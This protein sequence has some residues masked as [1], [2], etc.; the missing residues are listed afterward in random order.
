MD[1]PMPFRAEAEIKD[2]ADDSS[3]VIAR[4]QAGDDAAFG[5]LFERHYRFVY[6]FIYAMRGEQSA[7]EELTQETF[8]AAYKN[9]RGLR[10]EA[11]LQTWLCAIAK[12]IIYKS[13][14]LS[15]KE[16]VQSADEIESFEMPDEK[17]L[18]PDRQFLSKELNQV[19]GAALEKLDFD[20]RL[21][22]TLKEL[23]HLSYKEISDIT[24]SSIPKL[25]TDLRRAK[26][27]MRDTLEPYLEAGK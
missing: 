21:V 9:I 1:I 25:K 6:K 13:L 17:T 2:L 14:R 19:I 4:A 26:I 23:Q 20:K 15:R 10:G 18:A 16:G 8:L 3:E 24:G 12:N 5:L 27:E 7:A 22:F 11:K